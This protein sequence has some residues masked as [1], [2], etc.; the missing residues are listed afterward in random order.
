[1]IQATLSF[2]GLY[3]ANPHLLDNLHLPAQIDAEELKKRL[4]IET[5]DQE[6]LYPDAGFM[7]E[8]LEN[9]T[10]LRLHAWEQMAKV[11]MRENYDPFTNVNRHE[12]RTETET[13]DLTSTLQGT[14]TG[15]VSAY[16]LTSFT[17][18]D[19]N[20]TD[21]TGRDSG[22]IK[23]TMSYDLEGDSAI[24]DTQDLIRKEIKLRSQFSLFSIIISDIKQ[25][26]CLGVY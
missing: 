19:Q 5:A 22:T 24:S 15:K 2:M 18:K 20:L 6:V 14:N 8:A 13:R 7:A 26:F 4:L 21:S 23:K 17:D 3:R 11:L 25:N 9:Y 1:M 10:A 12:E 16:N